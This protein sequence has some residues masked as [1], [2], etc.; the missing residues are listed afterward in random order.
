MT[1]VWIVLESTDGETEIVDVFDSE[2]KADKCIEDWQ[3]AGE[4]QAESFTTETRWIENRE[5]L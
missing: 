3:R 5:V 2:E 1:S 4:K